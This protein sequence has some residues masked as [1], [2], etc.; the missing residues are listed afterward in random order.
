MYTF[1]HTC[2]HIYIHLYTG[3][4]GVMLTVVGR[5]HGDLSSNPGQGCIIH[6]PNTLEKGIN[7]TI[8]PPSMG[9]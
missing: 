3:T 6:S 9:K 7:P 2:I 4:H 1:K 8:L 5:R